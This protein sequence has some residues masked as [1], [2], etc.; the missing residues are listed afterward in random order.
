MMLARNSGRALE[1]NP[2]LKK[3]KRALDFKGS[4]GH[5]RM[6]EGRD[7]MVGVGG[8]ASEFVDILMF[9][10]CR[11]LDREVCVGNALKHTVIELI[12]QDTVPVVMS[13]EQANKQDI[14]GHAVQCNLVLGG[15]MFGTR[16]HI[17]AHAMMCL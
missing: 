2:P 10:N 4:S 11:R 16:A 15:G 12:K 3:Y 17:H 5:R 13:K 7:F 8:E 1:Y 6:S 9:V 14:C